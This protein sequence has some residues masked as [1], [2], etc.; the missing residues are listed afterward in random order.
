MA[1]E[2]LDTANLAGAPLPEV[3]YYVAASLD[4]FIATPDGSV[5]WLAPFEGSGED[6]GYAEFLAGVDGL[7]M[8]RRTYEQSLGFGPWPYGAKPAW[9]FSHAPVQAVDGVAV[10]DRSPAQVVAEAAALGLRRL[11]LVGGA[12]LAASF[13][14]AGL[15]SEYIVSVMPVVLGGGVPL[16]ST[17]GTPEDLRLVEATT[18]ADGV[19]QL[20]YRA[21]RA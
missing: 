16:L 18:Y 6:Y 4:G 11:W 12:T 3:V 15:I 14:G 5:A 9:V 2:I 1:E 20:R 10:T 8:G 7:V 13:R 19:V 21:R 17:P